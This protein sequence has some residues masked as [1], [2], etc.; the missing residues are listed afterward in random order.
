MA[1]LEKL[2]MEITGIDKV[3]IMQAWRDIMVFVDPQQVDDAWTQKL[4]ETI[5]EKVE[6]QL[7]YPGI[8]RV[9]TI[10]EY[11]IVDYLR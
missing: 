1:E 7:D 3:H 8:I 10:R 5:A 6:E 11:K 2:I 4:M 9:S